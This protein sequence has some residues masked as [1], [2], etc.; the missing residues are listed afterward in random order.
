MPL[1]VIDNPESLAYVIA[2]SGASLLLVNSPERWAALAPYQLRFPN[3][4]RVVYLRGPGETAPAGISLP[5]DAWLTDAERQPL[6][7]DRPVTP[8]SLAAIVYT[9]GTTGPPKGV[10][11]S[12]RNVISNV[13]ASM[14]AVRVRDDDLFL[15]FLPLSHTFERTVGYYLPIAAGA[16]VAFARS[17]PL[18]MADLAAIRPTILVSVP[19]IYERAYAALKE[20]VDRHRVSRQL[21]A[22]TVGIGWR[23]FEHSQGRL[24]R[25]PLLARMLWPLLDRLVASPVRAR[26]GGRLR[27]AVTGGAAM[28]PDIA[29]P[30][31]ALGVPLL[32][33][34]GMTESSPVI[35]C[36]TLEDN[37]PASVGRALRGVAV[38]IGE[39]EE[40]LARGENVM[41]GYWQRPEETVRARDP[42]GWLHTGDQARLDGGRIYIKG[43]LKDIIVTSTGEKIA[44]ADL[45]AAITSDPLFDQAM[46]IGEQRPYLATLVV[47][48]SA[49]WAQQAHDLGL[50]PDN[51]SDLHSEPARRSVLERIRAA[52][53]A[54]PSHAT[55][56]A[57]F[58]S[59]EPWT[60][61]NGLITPTLKPKRAAIEARYAAEIAEL[62]RGH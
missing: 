5:L 57:V 45:E 38:R 17:V 39:N 24:P 25:P 26:F 48:N 49:K 10:M 50:N 53:Q 33:G 16:S 6:P 60:V 9:S 42:D 12:H 7:A 47:V 40:L 19:R 15:S 52:L 31:L 21:F 46:V 41:L 36:N 22:L 4:K 58:L 34:Y 59:K 27:G 37:E 11:L 32:Q 2:D 56:R 14:A 30:F 43:R 18:L 20:S 1:H 13:N 61:A 62:Y 35:A 54:F 29:R 44:P 23:R 8:D 3:L 55:P 28:A 51:E